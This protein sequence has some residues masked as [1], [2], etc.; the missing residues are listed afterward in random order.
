MELE[1]KNLEVE[2]ELKTGTEFFAT[3]TA[4]ITS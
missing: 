1:L 2:L 4:A 3:A